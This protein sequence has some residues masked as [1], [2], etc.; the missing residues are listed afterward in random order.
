L[1]LGLLF[2]L[3]FGLFEVA[4]LFFFLLP[5]GLAELALKCALLCGSLPFFQRLRSGFGLA[6]P[7]HD[8][9]E[10]RFFHI[11][12]KRLALFLCQK[13][14]S[15]KI[16][17]FVVDALSLPGRAILTTLLKPWFVLGKLLHDGTQ[18]FMAGRNILILCRCSRR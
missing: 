16:H 5:V 15:R 8:T 3:L 18:L 17:Q 9:R 10:G 12:R 2:G 13:I 6:L 4:L 1:F 7:G 14:P 11:F